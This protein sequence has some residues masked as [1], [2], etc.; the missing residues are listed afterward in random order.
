[1]PAK[2]QPKKKSP[3]TNPRAEE[4][5][6]QTQHVEHGGAQKGAIVDSKVVG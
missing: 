2:T 5:D 4:K 1:M 6:V 3:P